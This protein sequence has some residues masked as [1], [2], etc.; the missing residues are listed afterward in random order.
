MVANNKLSGIFKEVVMAQFNALSK[1]FLEG[2]EGND[3]KS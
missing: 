1:F 2:T 3:D